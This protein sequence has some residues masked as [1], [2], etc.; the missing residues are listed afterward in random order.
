MDNENQPSAAPLSP[1]GNGAQRPPRRRRNRGNR[2]NQPTSNGATTPVAGGATSSA[3]VAGAQYTQNNHQDRYLRPSLSQHGARPRPGVMRTNTIRR[4]STPATGVDAPVNGLRPRMTPNPRLAQGRPPMN[5][6]PS[7]RPAA[8]GGEKPTDAPRTGLTKR[9]FNSNR[10]IDTKPGIV[11]AIQKDVADNPV[12]QIVLSSG[13]RKLRIIPLGG[14]GEVG[15]KNMTVFE[16]GEDIVVVDCGIA[17]AG[18]EYPGVDALIPDVS[19]LEARKKNVRGMIITH[20]HLDHIGA[21]PYIWPKLN[22][23]IYATPLAGGLIEHSLEESGIKNAPITAINEG[24]KLHF[25]KISVEMVRL[26]HSIPDALGLAVR[27]PA[28]LFF[29]A[30]D[31]R[32]EHTPALGKPIDWARIAQ[33]SAEGITALFSDS[34]NV[35]Y[36]GYTPTEGIIGEAFDK[37]FSEA[38]G[39]IIIAQFASNINRVQQVLNS[40]KKFNRKVALS[41][42]SMEN[43]INTAMRLG[44]LKVPEN[45][46]VDLKKIGTIEPHKIAVLST[47]SQ[48]EE[49]SSMTRIA[50]GEHRSITLDKTDTVVMSSS[51]IPGNDYSVGKMLDNLY[52]SGAKIINKKLMNDIHVT[53]HPNRDELKMMIAMTQPKYMIPIHG[54]YHHIF[55][56]GKVAVEMGVEEDKVILMENGQ[57][58]EFDEQGGRV[59][60]ERVQL[61]DVMIDGIGVGDVGP[62]VIRDRLAMGKE[63]IVTVFMVVDKNGQMITSPDIITRGFVYVREAE[64][65]MRKLREEIKRSYTQAL[66][67]HGNNWDEIKGFVRDDIQAFISQNTA[68][69]PMVIPVITTIDK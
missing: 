7:A 15:S 21:V 46:L 44:Y 58:L 40:A 45:M 24:D 55:E 59:A 42:R 68:R 57:I 29:Y 18:P 27:C 41:G 2:P 6:R 49:F 51:V 69:N 53:G 28:G 66:S 38:K 61:E 52:R 33:L 23:P 11:A 67:R 25:G 32:L 13:S 22:C 65:M 30:T 47:G 1:Q 60:T 36:P 12:E 5:R 4:T 8:V 37:I 31:W 26:T 64:D 19:Y 39:R 62:I 43:Y 35:D 20:G 54:D 63:G 17:F 3:P 9:R 34:T 56:H 10:P 16:Y 14:A 50:G 48:G